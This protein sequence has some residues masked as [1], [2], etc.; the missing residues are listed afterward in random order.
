MITGKTSLYMKILLFMLVYPAQSVSLFITM[1]MSYVDSR[2]S[3]P[4]PYNNFGELYA[5]YNA[6]FAFWIYFIM[7]FSGVGLI[8]LAW[9]VIKDAP[10]G[11]PRRYSFPPHPPSGEQAIVNEPAQE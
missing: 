9:F 8:F 11:D 6:D 5:K 1:A 2:P 10:A 3:V 4:I 7:F